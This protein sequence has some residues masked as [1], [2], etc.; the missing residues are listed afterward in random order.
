VFG[1]QAYHLIL[2]LEAESEDALLEAFEALE[3]SG[4]LWSTVDV[5]VN[6]NLLTVSFS[7]PTGPGDLT[8]RI[9]V[10]DL[11][12]ATL[13]AG[14]F[15]LHV[16]ARLGNRAPTLSGPALVLLEASGVTPL[17]LTGED[18]DG[19]LLRYTV[20]GAP[21]GL[22]V[23]D[24]GAGAFRLTHNSL[25]TNLTATLLVVADDGWGLAATLSVVVVVFEPGRLPQV[26]ALATAD[27]AGTVWINGT[28]AVWSQPPGAPALVAT[29]VFDQTLTY[30]ISAA[31][32]SFAFLIPQT[33]AVGNH[34]VDITVRDGFGRTGTAH[35]R[36]AV[37]P[38]PQPLP[39]L[40]AIAL[41]GAVT[42]EVA[43]NVP[44]TLTLGSASPF[45]SDV[46]IR[47]LID[48]LEVGRGRSLQVTF[49]PGPHTIRAEATN[50]VET[51]FLE[52]QVTVT[53]P[54]AP[55]N[56]PA[57]GGDLGPVVAAAA[58]GGGLA[59]VA[60]GWFFT[61]RRGK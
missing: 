51:K 34:T 23:R 22:L 18:A 55:P 20:T 7:G 6:G 8:Y 21:A 32:G 38:P 10:T 15:N 53:A 29:I 49:T 48:G 19:D 13:M 4:S 46:E 24:E 9:L 25:D 16:S 43:A 52:A 12:G 40:T 26:A 2:K 44:V 17:T 37:L 1:H 27:R 54:A 35:I 14:P 45:S 31:G 60:A 50:G 11:R 41:N 57:P 39:A 61:R 33:V 36:F 28:V 30:E 47:W 56:P 42:S 3:D 59:V 5:A 58:V